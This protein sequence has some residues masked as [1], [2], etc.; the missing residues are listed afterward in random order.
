MDNRKN[1]AI[2]DTK[3]LDDE[4][5]YH[6]ITY[7]NTSCKIMTRMVAKYMSEHTMKNE[8]WDE[9]QSGAVEGVLGRSMHCGKSETIP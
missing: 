2:A 8:I 3:S 7:L 1:C 9:G 5:D 4:K 6:P